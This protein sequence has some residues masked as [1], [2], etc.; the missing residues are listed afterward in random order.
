[1]TARVAVQVPE[2]IYQDPRLGKSRRQET[3]ND[4]WTRQEEDGEL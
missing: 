2:D 4:V 1:M 3:C